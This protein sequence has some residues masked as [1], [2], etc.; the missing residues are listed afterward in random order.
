MKYVNAYSGKCLEVADWRT[1]NGA[2]VRQWDCTGQPNQRWMVRVSTHGV[3]V[4]NKHSGKCLEV[5]DWR[6]DNGAPVR[7]WDCTGQPNQQW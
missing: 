5:A 1:D 2:P 4:V 3:V 6:T 7:Q